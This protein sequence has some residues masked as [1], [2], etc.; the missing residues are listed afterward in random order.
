MSFD[1]VY[2]PVTQQSQNNISSI[3]RIV[4]PATFLA[5]LFSAHL[6]PTV[7]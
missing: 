4:M 7:P 5:S 3:F 2:L 1:N 6:L